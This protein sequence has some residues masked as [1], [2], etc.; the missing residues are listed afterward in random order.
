MALIVAS[1]P[2][3]TNLN[4]SIL[5]TSLTIS[6]AISNSLAVGAPKDKLF[7][8]TSCIAFKTSSFACPKIMGP[9]ELI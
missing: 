9:H 7:K 5:G 2:L 3:L 1:V 4:C 6:S 8:D